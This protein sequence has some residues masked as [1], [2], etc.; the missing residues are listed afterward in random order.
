MGKI[1]IFDPETSAFVSPRDAYPADVLAVISDEE[2]DRSAVRWH[3]AGSATELQ[4]FE[5]QL[6]PGARLAPH[7]HAASEIIAVLSGELVVGST[8][9]GAGASFLV[10]GGTVYS[11]SAGD[12]G[13]RFFNFRAAADTTYFTREQALERRRAETAAP[14]DE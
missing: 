1:T 12:E 3:H 2:L 7:A 5:M 11:V 6:E 14:G 10:P 8:G 4:M 13:C 9:Y